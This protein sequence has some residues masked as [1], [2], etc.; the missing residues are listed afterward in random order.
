[1]APAK[2]EYQQ[3]SI[4]F[5]GVYSKNREEYAVVDIAASLFGFVT[6]PVYDTLGVEAFAFILNQTNLETVFLSEEC[7][8]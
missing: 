2:K 8:V 6:V 7:L 4:K 3:F 1:L 5:L